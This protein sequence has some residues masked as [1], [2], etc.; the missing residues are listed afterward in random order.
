[1][2][3][4]QHNTLSGADLHVPKA[5]GNSAHDA[6]ARDMGNMV[7]DTDAK[8]LTAAERTKLAGIEV[9]ADVTDATNVAAAGAVMNTGNET[10]A[11]VKTFSSSPVVPAPTTDLQAATKKYVDDNSGSPN[12]TTKGDLQG[13]STVAARVPVGANATVL[14]ADSTQALGVKWSVPAGGGDVTKAGTPVDSQ[15]GVWTGDGTIEGTAELTYDTLGLGLS[16][17]YDGLYGTTITNSFAGA[18]VIAGAISKVVNDE[19]YWGLVGMTS[20]ASTIS[21]G[22]L[23]NTFHVYNQGYA[24]TLFTVDGNNDFVWFSDPTDSHDFSALSNEIMRLSAD[25]TLD[26]DGDITLTGTVDGIDVATDVTANTA[27]VTNATHSGDVTGSGALSIA[28]DAVTYAKMQ[29]VVADDRILGNISGA[30]SA[31]AELTGA[32]VLALLTLPVELTVAVSD[33]DTDLTTGTAKLTFRMPYAMTLT[34]V[35][36]SVNTAPTGAN[37]VVDVN[38]AGTTVLSTKISIDE[39]DKTSSFSSTPPVISDSALADDAEMTID[40]DQIGSTIAGK[41]LKVTLIGTRA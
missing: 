8:I 32:Q 6:T 23:I 11:G 3:D 33:E 27:K 10:V 12:V 2:A 39:D 21:S 1:M 7:E 4:K 26:L 17:S 20:S 38:E 35:R 5:H 40:L 13:F 29:N 19:G 14:T 28:A 31:V 30:D 25:G 36:A 41:G 22:A 9:L 24:D 34:E 37:I 15:V 16:K 18:V